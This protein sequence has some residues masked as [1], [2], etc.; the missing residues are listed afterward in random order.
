MVIRY[1]SPIGQIDTGHLDLL[2]MRWRQ[3]AFRYIGC[4]AGMRLATRFLGNPCFCSVNTKN[5]YDWKRRQNKSIES[6]DHF[7]P[8]T[9]HST[10]TQVHFAFLEAVCGSGAFLTLGSRIRDEQPGSYF[11]ELRNNL[12]GLKSVLWNRNYLLRFRFRFRFWLL[13]SYGSGSGSDFW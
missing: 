5:I 1:W 6:W 4:I 3:R 12:F 10:S 13:K 7:G 11:R 2:Q 8:T 9:L